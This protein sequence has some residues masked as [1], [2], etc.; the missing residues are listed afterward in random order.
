MPWTMQQF[1][2]LMSKGSPLSEKKKAEM[3]AEVHGRPELI[4]KAAAIVKKKKKKSS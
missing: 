3:K 1:R 2:Y 4:R